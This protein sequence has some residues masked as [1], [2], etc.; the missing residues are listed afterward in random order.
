MVESSPK[1][2]DLGEVFMLQYVAVSEKLLFFE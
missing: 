2:G 1:L